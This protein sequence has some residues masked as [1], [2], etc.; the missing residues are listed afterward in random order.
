FNAVSQRALFEAVQR[1]A[2]VAPEL[3][4]CM[5]RAQCMIR[6]SGAAEMVMRGRYPSGQTQPFV[7]DRFAR[8]GGQGCPDMP[9]A[10][11]EVIAATDLEAEAAMGDVRGSMT[12]DEASA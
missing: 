1:I 10:F 5:L 3:A 11:A 7:V 9:A 4:A 6:G 2:N 12:A 8:G